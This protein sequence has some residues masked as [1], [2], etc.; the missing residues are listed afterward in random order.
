MKPLADWRDPAAPHARSGTCAATHLLAP[1]R[2]YPL[3]RGTAPAASRIECSLTIGLSAQEG[4]R[5]LL[6]GARRGSVGA[7]TK[8]RSPA[9]W[10]CIGGQVQQQQLAPGG[11]S[12][13][14]R[15][16]WRRRR[17]AAGRTCCA[18]V[19]E[20]QDRGF[21]KQGSCQELLDQVLVRHF[22]ESQF[23]LATFGAGLQTGQIE[24]KK[25]RKFLQVQFKTV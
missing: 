22:D 4:Q 15:F 21:R 12:P 6:S 17:G 25:E 24:K 13:A 7:V 2:L 19:D 9:R 23:N 5:T 20:E 1:C 8:A 18:A 16:R 10:F 11:R 3:S 14:T